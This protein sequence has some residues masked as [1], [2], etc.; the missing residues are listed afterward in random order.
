MKNGH[1]PVFLLAALGLFPAL[2][3]AQPA[4]DTSQWKCEN[5]PYP[6]GATGAIE[7]GIG[8]VSEDST[9][10][11]SYTGLDQKG[12]F[13]VLGGNV[14]YRGDGYW[15]DLRAADL[16]LDTRGVLA[17]VGREGLYSLRIGYAEL[18]RFATD[19]AASPFLGI[20]SNDLTLPAGFPAAT[21]A[22]MPLA[23]TLQSV[24]LGTQRKRFEVGGSFVGMANWVYRVSMRH[25]VREGTLAGS[26]SHFATA[27]QLAFP[28]DQT[29]DQFELSAS[30][31]SARLQATL[32][33][34][35]SQF[36][37]GPTSLAWDNPFSPV[38]GADR[39]RLALAPD[40]SFQQVFGSAGYQLTPT[41]RASAD[42]AIGRMT[43]DDAYLPST[44]NAAL[45]GLPALPASS[46]DGRVSTYA[47]TVRLSA[48][49]LA[50]LR[51]HA[52]WSHDER[53]NRTVVAA[54]PQVAT[55]MFPATQLRSNTPFSF[56][57]DR[58][59]VGADYRGPGSWKF[60]GG[61]DHERR[62]RSYAEVV[63]TRETSLWARA[64]V[65]ALENLALS[66]KLSASERDHS[67]YGVATWFG[68]PEN[69][70]LRKFNL[71][72]RTRH[73]GGVRGDL[74]VSEQ[75]SVGLSAD[76]ANDDYDKSLIGLKEARSSS[77]GADL[78][79][80]LSEST[81]ITAYA[82]GERVRSRQD[83]SLAYGAPDWSGRVEDRFEMVGLGVRHAAIPDKLDIGADLSVSRSRS[84][85]A[86]RTGVGEPA[87]PTQKV[88]LDSVRLFATYRLNEKM[89]V[90]GSLW[91]EEYGAQ[92]WRL[93]GVAADTLPN[94]L[95]FGQQA[96]SYRV[97]VIRVALRYQ[98]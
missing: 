8:S 20:G 40:N 46:L 1:T 19:G 18:P 80:N 34:S 13:A 56:V 70:L 83:G 36:R 78:A 27:A 52:S 73:S 17:R 7:A 62:E 12:A 14:S 21:T 25:D 90:T 38:A 5:C 9:T 35:L 72:A 67:S 89:S 39:G 88:S 44:I 59:K 76:F 93:D 30:Y 28:V 98:F 24:E 50:G 32:G 65:Q 79:V 96:P 63:D 92:D 45:T 68:A 2:G 11:G 53:D 87:F 82:H 74:T 57:L 48:A 55:D 16:G 91:H 69:P 29:T 86:V 15:A 49:P 71:A 97:N 22:G 94:L 23:S 84:D 95:T 85:V 60:A 58:F 31:V 64:S 75:V 81:Q 3:T 42:F 66:G 51:V 41:I 77:F 10:F 47:G 26:A 4:V 43:Q 33:Y 54:Y 6:K 37:N 61:L